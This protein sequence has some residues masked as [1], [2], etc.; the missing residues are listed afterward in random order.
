MTEYI[1]DYENYDPD[2]EDLIDDMNVYTMNFTLST[3]K[4]SHSFAFIKFD[5]P[6]TNYYHVDVVIG[7]EVSD[8]YDYAYY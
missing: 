7:L 6:A 8:R 3:S 2:V 4:F 1:A 5:N